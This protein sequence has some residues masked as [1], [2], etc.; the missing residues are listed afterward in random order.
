MIVNI[1][2][3][4]YVSLKMPAYQVCSDYD[5][6]LTLTYIASRPNLLPNA[7]T[8]EKMI[9]ETSLFS[10]DMF[11]LMWKFHRSRLTFDLSAKVAHIGVPSIMKT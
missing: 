9:F 4:L 10:F 3:P 6:R 8:W 5:P 11:N 2:G 1:N 7:F